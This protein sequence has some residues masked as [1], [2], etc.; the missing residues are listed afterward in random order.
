MPRKSKLILTWVLVGFAIYAVI[1]SPER[2]ADIVHAVVD[3]VAEA[4]RSIGR[5][6]TELFS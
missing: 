5:F 6:F 3:I 1:T 4:L 2:A